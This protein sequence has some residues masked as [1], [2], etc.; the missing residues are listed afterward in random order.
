MLN[1]V[2]PVMSDGST[3]GVNW[4]RRKE[5]PSEDAN[6]DT[7]V[8]LPSPGISSIKTW[9]EHSRAISSRSTT[10]SLPT[11]TFFTF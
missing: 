6:A 11:M 2:K 8:V 9:P 1:M 5:Q 7:I 10:S 3:S 4:M